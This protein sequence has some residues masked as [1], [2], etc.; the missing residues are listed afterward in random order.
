VCL[1]KNTSFRPG[2][3]DGIFTYQKGQFGNI[4]EG[5]GMENVGV[6]FLWQ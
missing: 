1:Q 6:P 2:F 3:P 4:L 5:F